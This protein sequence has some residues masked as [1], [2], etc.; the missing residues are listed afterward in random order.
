MRLNNECLKNVDSSLFRTVLPIQMSYICL[1]RSSL[2]LKV[3]HSV[4]EFKGIDRPIVTTGTFDGIHV[5]HNH[6]LKRLK[7]IAEEVNGETVLLTFSPHPRIVL[8]PDNHGLKLLNTREE[9]IKQLSKCGIDHLI[10][11]P[12]TLDFSKRSALQYVKELLVEGLGVNTIVV[13][14]D[15]RFGKGREGNYDKLL[16]FAKMFNFK[17][18]EIPAQMIQD[19]N[20]SSTKIRNAIASGDVKTANTYLGYNYPLTGIVIEGDSL[21]RTL[22]FPTANL[23]IK[24][25]LKIIPGIGVYAVKV[26]YKGEAFKGMLNIGHRPTVTTSSELRIEVHLIDENIHL[27]GEELELEFISK[28]RD[29]QK[30]ETKEDLVKQLKE[31]QI[32][33]LDK[34]K[35]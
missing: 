35:E 26:H 24:D 2:D 23:S 34:L 4:R 20:V 32:A 12:F 7:S 31:D 19:T 17:V 22:G 8:F 5:G 15:H 18:E 33:V 25:E 28:I 13:G 1:A 3:Y 21:G 30:F 14:Y 10:I 29:E 16:Q 11:Q 9:Q 27:Y 6:I